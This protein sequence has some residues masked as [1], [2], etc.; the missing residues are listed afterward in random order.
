MVVGMEPWEQSVGG[1]LGMIIG[2][3]VGPFAQ[4]GLDE[5]FGLAIG[6]RGIGTGKDVPH[7][8][9]AAQGGNKG[10]TVG[11]AVISHDASHRDSKG[12]EVIEGAREECSSGLFALV[13][14]NFRVGQARMV[15]DTNV[16]DFEAGTETAFLVSTC[17][18]GADAME[19]A[20]LLGVEMEQLA[21]RR[22]LVANDGRRRVQGAQ[23]G[24]SSPLEQAAYGGEAELELYGDML[25]QEALAAQ[26]DRLLDQCRRC[27]ATQSVRTRAAVGQSGRTFAGET[28]GPLAHGLVTYARARGDRLGQ[29]SSIHPPD[30]SGS[31]IRRGARILMNVHPG[32]PPESVLSFAPFTFPASSRKD[33]L[34]KLHS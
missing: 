32:R 4:S 27:R 12:L 13:G 6:A 5:A 22:V 17:D 34:L 14:Q 2:A 24:Q 33:N 19:A 10:R 9:A 18:A 11:G 15:V 25:H 1:L 20:E 29:F 31:T 7:P 23:P 26:R 16:G 8:A 30:Q 3:C 21:G 28:P